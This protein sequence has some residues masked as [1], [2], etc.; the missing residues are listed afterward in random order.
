LGPEPWGP[1]PRALVE[2]GVTTAA[3]GN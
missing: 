3:K 1:V 2:R